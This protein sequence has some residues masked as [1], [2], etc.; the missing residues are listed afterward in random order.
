MD[1]RL[2]I[3][4]APETIPGGTAVLLL[5]PSTGETDRID[6][7]FLKTDTDSFLVISTRT[8]ARE[9]MQKLDHYDVDET[10][11]KILDTL[12]VDRGYS[13]R[14]AENIRYVSSPDDVD[15]ILTVTDEFLA[16]TEGKRRVSFD[17][18]TELAYYADDERA[19]DALDRL[20]RLLETS[21]AVGLFHVST[22]VHDA[23]TID[24]FRDL[25]DGVL[26]LHE[27]GGLDVDF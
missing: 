11:A 10:S 3:D 26:D 1:Y 15:G 21:D 19:I 9:V 18:I 5:H 22:E 12:S 16:D 27:D 14:S 25:C 20:T 8:T 4:G 7:D 2:A 23:E 24:R 17:S 6:T 13:R